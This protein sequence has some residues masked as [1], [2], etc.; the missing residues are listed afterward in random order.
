ML[1]FTLLHSQ[2]AEDRN[3]SRLGGRQDFTLLQR[4]DRNPD[5]IL[6]RCQSRTVCESEFLLL[7]K[8]NLT[9]MARIDVVVCSDGDG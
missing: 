9:C 2:T 4:P 1:Y 7:I 3:E 5:D 8:L 6:T